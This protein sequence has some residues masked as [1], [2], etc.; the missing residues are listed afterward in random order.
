ML[1][2]LGFA[3]FLSLVM[4]YWNYKFLVNLFHKDCNKCSINDYCF[5]HKCNVYENV[6]VSAFRGYIKEILK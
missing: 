6:C 1:L 3:L 5:T 2:A 4:I